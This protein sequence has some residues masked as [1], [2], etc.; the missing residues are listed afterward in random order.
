MKSIAPG[1]PFTVALKLQHP[2]GGWHSYYKNSGGIEKSPEVKWTLPEGFTASELQWPVPHVTDGL[3]G[4]SF[5]YSGTPVFLTQITPPANLA[6][7]S[8]VTLKASA[9]W[10]ICREGQCRDEPKEGPAKFEITLPVAGAPEMDGAQAAL[11]TAARAEIP[12]P[13]KD[14]KVSVEA[15]G[16][17]LQLRLKGV[18]TDL[19]QASL[20]FIPDYPFIALAQNGAG[21]T[22]DGDDWLLALKRVT[23][24]PVFDHAVPQGKQVA[25]ILVGTNPINGASKAVAIPPTTIGKAPA[26]P[27]S[28]G[29]FLPILGGMLL[30]GLILNLMPCV[31]PVIGL[32]IMGFVQQSGQDR[33]KIVLHG[34]A[35]TAGVLLSFWA[36]SGVLFALRSAAGPGQEIGWG[37]Q[38]QN[39]WTVLVLMLLMFILG[40]SMYGVFEIGASATSVGGKLQTKDGVSGSFFSGILATVVATP[41]SAPFL[42]AAIGAA[43]AL[44]PVQFFTAFTAMALGLS[45]PYLILSIFP[46]L[47]DLLPRPGAWM[48]SFK[49]AMAFLLFATAG[50]LLWVYVG[51]IELDNMLNVIFGLTAVAIAAWIFGR[52]HTPFRSR[53]A[54]TIALVLT[55]LFAAGGMKLAAPP[56][57]SELV[58]EAWSEARVNELLEDGKPVYVDFTAKWCATCQLNKK[59]AYPKE[60]AALMKDRGIVLMRGDK[61]NPNP[62]IDAKLEELGRSAIP[63][64]VLYVPGKEP[65]ITPELLDAGYMKDLITREVPLP[66]KK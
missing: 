20:S 44:P 24:D 33:K 26:A 29:K 32:K 65:V 54:R 63:V 35:F 11:F 22:R 45:L 47:V 12:Q 41:C 9:V 1:K 19:S 66:E 13:S 25:G 34:L 57:K 6:D 55:V 2:S 52:W 14:W 8:K 48:E 28:L 53:K 56:A 51:Q 31:F 5:T 49:Q 59:R 3:F 4:K 27:L 42:G 15:S 40:L 39:P 10:Q 62:A 36:L 46:R 50:Y 58:W 60:V 23:K 61:T 7:G 64:N 18:S 38:L 43:I 30:G 16:T 37:Y 17:E 21:L